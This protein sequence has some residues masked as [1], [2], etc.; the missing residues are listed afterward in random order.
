M[1]LRADALMIM[2]PHWGDY[3]AIN[4]TCSREPKTIISFQRTREV[5]PHFGHQGVMETTTAAW[6][7]CLR[8]IVPLNSRRGGQQS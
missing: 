8:R 7:F 4:G 3:S 1:A 6:K 2:S 5:W